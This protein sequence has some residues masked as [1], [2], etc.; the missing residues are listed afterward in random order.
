MNENK[1]KVEKEKSIID[2]IFIVGAGLAV[3]LLIVGNFISKF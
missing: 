1:E 3:V 2:W